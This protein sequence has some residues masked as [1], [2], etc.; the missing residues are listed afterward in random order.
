MDFRVI[1]NGMKRI[2][3]SYGNGHNGVDL[4]FFKGEGDI[5]IYSNCVGV[6][7]EVVDGLDN[8]TR[9]SGS[10]S[11]GNYVY[12]RHPNGMF[13]RYAHLKK[14]ILVRK[15]D[16]VNAETVLGYMGDSGRAYGKHLHF[17]VSTGYSSRKRIN[18]TSFLTK[19]IY[20]QDT[21]MYDL[22]KLRLGIW[23]WKRGDR[24]KNVGLIQR[25]LNWS[26]NSNLAL[27]NSF[28]R[29]T[30]RAVLAYQKRFGLKED[31]KFGPAC[32]KM[33]KSLII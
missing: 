19:A 1:E 31:G 22:P 29:K 17:E 12:I 21:D 15:G 4:G 14:G 6:V 24:D 25:F 33:A 16:N 7:Y 30:E 9:S 26:M 28:G 27:D 5:P 2:T 11:W 18:P 13:S 32:L 3:N 10:K 8:N 20:D 23:G